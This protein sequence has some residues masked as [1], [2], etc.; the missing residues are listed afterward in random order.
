MVERALP[1]GGIAVDVSDIGLLDRPVT[2]AGVGEREPGRLGPHRV[3]G[4]L[5]PGLANGIMP[6]PATMTSEHRFLR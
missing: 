3:I 2:E 6:T 4:A 5:A 1:A